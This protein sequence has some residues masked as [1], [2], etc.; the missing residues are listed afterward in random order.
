MDPS[1][2][3]NE[4]RSLRRIYADLSMRADL[5][6]EAFGK[7]DWAISTPREGRNGGGAAVASMALAGRAFGVSEACYR[8]GPKLRTENEKI[9][10]LP[11]G[12]TDARKT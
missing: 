3:P 7:G 12:L 10:D 9:A 2:A 8:Y 1:A 5:L 6:K 4:N 11:T